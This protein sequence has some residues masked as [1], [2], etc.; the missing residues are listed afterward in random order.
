[1]STY[2]Y[3]QGHMMLSLMPNHCY[4]SLNI[5]KKFLKKNYLAKQVVRDYSVVLSI[6]MLMQIAKHLKGSTNLTD[7]SN[8]KSLFASMSSVA[9]K[10]L[11]LCI[12]PS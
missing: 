5:V 1:M 12:K 6:F 4:I 11:W 7:Y 2:K 3:T 9:F 10:V 8:S